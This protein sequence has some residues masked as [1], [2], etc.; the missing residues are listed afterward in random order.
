MA[1]ARG[2]SY[3]M[4]MTHDPSISQAPF[5]K[6]SDGTAA[7]LFTLRRGA[8]E[9]RI[10]NYGGI[11]TALITPDRQGRPG[12]VVLGYDH[13]DGYLRN[14]PYFGALVGRYGNRIA[15]GKFSLNGV[16][17]SLPVNNGP[18]CLHGGLRGF[19]KVVWKAKPVSDIPALELTYVSKDGEEGFPGNLSVK[20]VYLAH[21]RQRPA[22]RLHR[23]DGQRH[24]LEFDP[25]HLFQSR[26]PRRC[27]V[28]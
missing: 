27:A 2:T 18:N 12:D 14:S 22:P 13:L 25:A 3:K 17:Y 23:D 1:S 8:I 11:V 16:T 9:A 28:A 21:G 4:G 19:D 5:G 15:N 24:R 6:T 10:T 7:D 20:A 26:G